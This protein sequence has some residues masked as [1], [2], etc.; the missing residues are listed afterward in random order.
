MRREKPT[1]F[2]MKAGKDGPFKKNFPSVFKDRGNHAHPDGDMN[3]GQGPADIGGPR[4]DV[5]TDT[6]EIPGTPEIEREAQRAGDL[7]S[8]AVAR[9]REDLS[10]LD[11]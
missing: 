9:V 6:S 8:Q 3:H 2:R 5:L 10:M 4:T 1:A 11:T 7:Q